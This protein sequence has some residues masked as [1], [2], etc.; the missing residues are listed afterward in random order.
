MDDAKRK[1][2][3]IE[4]E[5]WRAMYESAPRPVVEALGLRVLDVE[6]ATLF[7]APRLPTGQ[8]NRAI[9]LGNERPPSD[10]GIDAV[11]ASARET[12]AS[13]FFVH[14]Y[15]GSALGGRLAA[16][17]LPLARRRAWAKMLHDGPLPEVPTSLRIGDV[18]R[19]QR[20]AL[21]RVLAAAHGMPPPIVP[22]VEAMIEHP[23][24]RAFGAYDEDALVA[25]GLLFLGK[26]GAWL[27]LGGTSPSHRNRG[28][29]GALM[30]RRV[31]EALEAGT[32]AI[33]TET[34]EPVADESNPSLA[35]MVRTGFRKVGSRLNFVA[36]GRGG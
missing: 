24:Y 23:G 31:K 4:C 20:T 14:A 8:F 21:A 11:V 25:G 5:A 33:E 34:G 10:A 19:T 36:I 1:A 29:Q 12:G 35:N 22:W 32:A 7:L 9:G 15:E 17:G 6:D 18:P 16:R 30:V 28:A 27:G 13:V 3:A 2:D 26:E